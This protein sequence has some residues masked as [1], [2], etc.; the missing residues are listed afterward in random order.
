MFAIREDKKPL[1]TVLLVSDMHLYLSVYISDARPKALLPVLACV[2]SCAC[3]KS[4]RG[5]TWISMPM[6]AQVFFLV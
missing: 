3:W 5:E 6:T 2:H 1:K 4:R